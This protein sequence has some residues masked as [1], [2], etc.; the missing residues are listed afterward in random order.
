MC[1]ILA[2]VR[3]GPRAILPTAPL[4]QATQTVQHRGPDDEG[5]LL[6]DGGGPARVFA[7]RDT[8]S[9]SRSAHRL[10]SL[11]EAARWQVAFGHRR[12]SI[13]DLSPAGHQPMIH[14]STGLAVIY[15]GEIYN[16]VEL[17]TDLEK[18]GHRFESHSDTEVLL[19]AWAE[20]GPECM[21]R[22]N[23]MFAFVMLDPRGRGG[24]GT[25]HAVRD[26][27]GV[28]P[29]Y[30]ARVGSF[31]AFAS[32]IKQLRSLPGFRPR[33]D[34][35]TARDFLVTGLMDV[36]TWTFD[37]SV[38]QLL[39]GSAA[40]VRLDV[41]DPV[42]ETSQWYTLTPERFSGSATDAA[43]RFRDL[44]QDSVRLRLRA[45]VP[46]GS[47]LSGGLD[48]S[49]I[50]CL[51]Y[52]E[53]QARDAH[54]GQVTVTARYESARHDE[55]HFAEQVVRQT[56]ATPVVVWPTVDRLKAE[57]DR[58]LWFMDEPFGS[59]SQFSQ[60]C[61]FVAAASAGLKVMLDGQGSDEQLAG[62]SGN[63]AALYAG[64][65]RRAAIL[66][67]AEEVISFRSR[68]GAFPL[69][70]LIL[71]ARNVAPFFDRLLPDRVRLVPGN[72]AWL[73]LGSP[74]RLSTESP[75]DLQTHLRQ[76]TLS[77][78]LPVLLRYE[79][80]NSMAQSIESRVPFLD[81]RLVE[82]VAGLPDYLRLRQGVTKVVLRDA[83]AGVLPEGVRARRDKMGFVTPEE[84]WLTE[85]AT[86]WFRE[87]VETAVEAAPD[88]FDADAVMT[89]L[90][91]MIE[92]RSAFSFLPWRILCMG[93][94][95]QATQGEHAPV[96]AGSEVG[97]G[98][99]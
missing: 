4:R 84:I 20:W 10:E 27:F 85:T 68:H 1:G 41:S 59:T 49:A 8:A 87:S 44:L 94:W 17:R 91:D 70:Q 56:G 16:H 18:L 61:V 88:I 66:P 71:G 65:M 75:R 11:P 53:L 79:D 46:L 30:Y 97:A 28:K 96:G 77:T 39:G 21:H 38:S 7:G 48:S 36:S 95:L 26:R 89:I 34:R 45:D 76:Q 40:T 19:A 64:M 23:G 5:Y 57:L 81:Y 72:P 51:A 63:D 33:L 86:D 83:M 74:S 69:A 78:S 80:R 47:C 67:L 25:L 13:V 62:Y 32:E 9:A 93:R 50:V 15:N 58:Q 54:A 2:L 73:R 43:T 35:A 14:K 98:V 3:C 55:W 90:D 12:L 52:R 37:E 82:F 6:W 24:G 99:E 31:L 60:W 42:V 29:L 22:F 92:H